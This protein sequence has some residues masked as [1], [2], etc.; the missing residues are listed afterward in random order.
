MKHWKK[1]AC[2]AVLVVGAYSIHMSHA[3]FVKTYRM[4]AAVVGDGKVSIQEFAEGAEGVLA[5][6]PEFGTEDVLRRYWPLL[7]DA[8][9][10]GSKNNEKV[11]RDIVEVF[12]EYSSDTSLDLK[13][14]GLMYGSLWIK[15]GREKDGDKAI[16]LFERML[17]V[18]RDSPT[19]LA[20]LYAFHKLKGADAMAQP[21]YDR[22]EEVYHTNPDAE[23]LCMVRK[24]ES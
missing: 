21:F 24:K 15:Y 14:N 9:G 13:W 10:K 18:R 20:C 17:E 2:L 5:Y 6:H 22:M 11:E 7:F 23:G 12:E 4:K 16:A 8:V 3:L 1:A 19:A